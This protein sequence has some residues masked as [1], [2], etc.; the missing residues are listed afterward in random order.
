MEKYLYLTKKSW[1]S[2]WV[3][4]GEIPLNVSSTYLSQER[5]GTMT[6]DENLLDSSTH[7]YS[8]FGSSIHIEGT[9]I[10][11]GQ[12]YRDGSLVASDI[13]VNRKFEDGL[14]LCFANS[15]S[16]EIA[17]RLGKEACVRI[18]NIYDLKKILDDQVGFESEM[19]ACE[20]TQGHHRNHFLKSDKDMWQ[21]EFRLFWKGKKSQMVTLPAGVGVEIS[22]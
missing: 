7:P 18:H 15:F 20:Y 19:R 6:P 9:D 8:I 5:Q 13:V 2:A 16:A 12:F 11:I 3:D 1:V 14:V 4:G 10:K 22:L 21:D 17:S